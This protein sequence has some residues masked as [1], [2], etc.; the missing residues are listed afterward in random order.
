ME[1]TVNEL[2]KIS[3]VSVRT[4]HYYHQIGLL[5]PLRVEENGY[6]IYGTAEVD[7]LQQI[8]FYKELGMPLNKIRDILYM[9]NLD[10][11]KLLEEQLTALLERKQQIESL[12]NNMKNTIRTLKGETTMSDK[13]KFEGFKKKM[14]EDNEAAY[15]KELRQRFG[16]EAIDASNK[17]VADMSQMQWESTQSFG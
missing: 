13:E 17:K 15:G 10:K 11:E 3:G 4:L 2:A 5:R 14:I 12:I 8:L 1:Y 6:R 7:Q 16:D 9:P